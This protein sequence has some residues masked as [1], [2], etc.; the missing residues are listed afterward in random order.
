MEG[1]APPH[2]APAVDASLSPSQRGFALS[3]SSEKRNLDFPLFEFLLSEQEFKYMDV[4]VNAAAA[5]SGDGLLHF[6]MF[7]SGELEG[8]DQQVEIFLCFLF[9]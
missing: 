8:L 3:H 6:E 9:S 5:S 4:R 2:K 7:W 1:E